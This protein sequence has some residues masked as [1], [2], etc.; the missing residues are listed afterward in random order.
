MNLSRKQKDSIG[1]KINK[2]EIYNDFFLTYFLTLSVSKGGGRH[3][4]ENSKCIRFTLFLYRDIRNVENRLVFRFV[5]NTP[6]G[7]ELLVK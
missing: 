1:F 2:I 7:G 6:G 5:Y 3:S 4:A